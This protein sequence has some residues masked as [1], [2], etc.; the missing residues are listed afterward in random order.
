MIFQSVGEEDKGVIAVVHECPL[1][2]ASMTVDNGKYSFEL[3][4]WKIVGPCTS[5]TRH[6]GAKLKHS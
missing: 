5:Y 6:F 1:P 4:P 3:N 2:K